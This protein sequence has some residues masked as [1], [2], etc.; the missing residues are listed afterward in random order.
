M[1][2]QVRPQDCSLHRYSNGMPFLINH[3][4]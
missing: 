2:P 1:P 3:L 4:K